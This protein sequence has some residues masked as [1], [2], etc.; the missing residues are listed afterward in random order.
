MCV[1]RRR[2]ATFGNSAYNACTSNLEIFILEADHTPLDHQLLPESSRLISME[3]YMRTTLF[4]PSAV[5][6]SDHHLVHLISTCPILTFFAFC[7]FD[8]LELELFF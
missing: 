8:F 1:V 4:L 5:F 3:D 7:C 2:E 6:F